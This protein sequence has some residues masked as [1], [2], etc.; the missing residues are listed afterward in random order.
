MPDILICAAGVFV[1]LELKTLEGKVS[2]LQEH[3]LAK[4]KQAQGMAFVVT[5]ENYIEVIGLISDLSVGVKDN[6]ISL[7]DYK[8]GNMITLN[9]LV[10]FTGRIQ[11]SLKCVMAQRGM[12]AK[13]AYKLNKIAAEIDM[14]TR[15]I[16]KEYY[17]WA[18]AYLDKNEKGQYIPNTGNKNFGN[19]QVKDDK[20]EEYSQK[21]LEFLNKEAK[22]TAPKISLDEVANLIVSSLDMQIL[23]PIFVEESVLPTA[24][25]PQTT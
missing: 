15:N 8:R 14:F 22:L 10:I 23:N 6:V 2:S 18:D 1:A 17:D 20:A 12:S 7:V 16:S 5:P 9:Y 24:E 13:T 21:F 25:Q 19:H 3:N 11:D 4:I